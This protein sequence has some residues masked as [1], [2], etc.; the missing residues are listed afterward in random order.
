MKS[1]ISVSDWVASGDYFEWRGHR[2][3]YHIKG[4]GPT[5]VLLHG[6]PTCSWDWAPLWNELS[7]YFHLITFDFKGFGLSDKPHRAIYTIAEQADITEALLSYL[8]FQESHIF[9]HDYGVTVAQELLARHE[10]RFREASLDGI[11]YQ[12]VVFLNGGLFPETHRP[13]PI[14]KLL[15][16]PVGGV[17]SQLLTFRA[18]AK[19]F[20]H[21]FGPHTKP[22]KETLKEH[23]HFISHQKGH[24]ITHRLLN[25]IQERYRQRERWVGALC[26]TQ[27]PL[28]LI[29]GPEDPVSGS[30]LVKRYRELL[31]EGDVISLDGIGHYPQLEDPRGVLRAFL[32]FHKRLHTLSLPGKD[33][34]PGID[35]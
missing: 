22:D 11:T 5:L 33:T 2:Y 14:Q 12:S 23:W 4:A 28:R 29:N 32:A 21:V 26:Q 18:F 7:E 35:L 34:L 30:H 3:F 17:L 19:S 8:G 1:R 16:S 20:V 24:R 31:P 25:Y 15:N 10:E 27:L 6:F 9:A 13:R